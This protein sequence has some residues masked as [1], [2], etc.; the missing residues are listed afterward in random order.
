VIVPN[1]FRAEANPRIRISF[2]VPVCS[3]FLPGIGLATLLCYDFGPVHD[4][5]F[6]LETESRI[7]ETNK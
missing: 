5:H 2:C 7:R 3:G 1:Q 4:R 6:V